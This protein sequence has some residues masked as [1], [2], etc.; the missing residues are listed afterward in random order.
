MG[1]RNVGLSGE[2]IMVSTW[3][4]SEKKIDKIILIIQYYKKLN[5]I[6]SEQELK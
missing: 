2:D 5:I 1:L 6:K 4:V 3:C